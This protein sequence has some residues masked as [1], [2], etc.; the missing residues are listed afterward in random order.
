MTSVE[1]CYF[2]LTVD[3]WRVGRVLL[4]V[5]RNRRFIRDGVGST[6]DPNSPYGLRGRKAT[7]NLASVR[8]PVLTLRLVPDT[9]CWCQSKIHL[10]G[11]SYSCVK[12]RPNYMFQNI[13]PRHAILNMIC[14][15]N[16]MLS[17]VNNYTYGNGIFF[18]WTVCV[19]VRESHH[20]H[21]HT[22][23]RGPR[24]LHTKFHLGVFSAGD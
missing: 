21:T 20:T 22:H 11:Q 12:H 2:P 15:L 13:A 19:C 7:L 23:P 6:G 8:Q 24:N 10:R 14:L 5:H 9:T 18:L 16:E 4:Y 17:E 3:Y 1:R